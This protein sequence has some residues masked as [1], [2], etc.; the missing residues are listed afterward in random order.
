MSLGCSIKV[1]PTPPKTE[2]KIKTTLTSC[3]RETMKFG[4]YPI[5]IVHGET[6]AF[7][8]GAQGL[9][10]VFLGST[11]RVETIGEARRGRHGARNHQAHRE[12]L[13]WN[14]WTVLRMRGRFRHG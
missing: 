5:F 10:T 11:V 1:M 9:V 13:R 4:E 3:L 7:L 2:S 14:G 12:A 8:P 6:A